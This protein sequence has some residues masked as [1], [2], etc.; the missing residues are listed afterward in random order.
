MYTL[1]GSL[2]L[3]DLWILL[4][5]QKGDVTRLSRP[6]FG[7]EDWLES[8]HYRDHLPLEGVSATDTSPWL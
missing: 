1:D 8:K 7:Q 2:T 6:V 5:S 3:T 4:R